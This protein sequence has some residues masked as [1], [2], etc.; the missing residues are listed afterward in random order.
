MR[1]ATRNQPEIELSIACVVSERQEVARA[2]SRMR[3]PSPCARRRTSRRMPKLGYGPRLKRKAARQGEVRS[4]R[5]WAGWLA[6]L[7]DRPIVADLTG[8]DGHTG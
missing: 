2:C 7:A 5:C 3:R 6:R 1:A 8:I 4:Q